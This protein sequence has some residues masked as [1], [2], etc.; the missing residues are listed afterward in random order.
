MSS[1]DRYEVADDVKLGPLK[2]PGNGFTGTLVATDRDYIYGKT[3]CS[4]V[5][6]QRKH[7]GQRYLTVSCPAEWVKEARRLADILIIESQEYKHTKGKGKGKND[8]VEAFDSMWQNESEFRQQSSRS[9][10]HMH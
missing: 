10:Q 6:R 8:G 4:A 9:V 1:Q 7:Q 5:V 3:W 2:L